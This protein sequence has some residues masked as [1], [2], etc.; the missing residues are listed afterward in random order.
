MNYRSR[1]LSFSFAVVVILLVVDFTTKGSEANTTLPSVERDFVVE[2]MFPLTVANGALS[3]GYVVA[4]QAMIYEIENINARKDV[5]PNATLA[6]E[7]FNDQNEDLHLI[8]AEAIRIVSQYRPSLECHAADKEKLCTKDNELPSSSSKPRVSAIIGPV[9]SGNTVPAASLLGLYNIPLIGFSASSSLLSDKSRFKSFL[10]TIPSDKY[11][12]MA[13]ASLVKRFGWNYVFFIASDDE[14]GRQGLASFK[15]AARELNVCT[16]SDVNIAFQGDEAA[17]QVREVVARLKKE[18]RVKVVVLFM[19]GSQAAAIVNEAKRQGVGNITWIFSDAIGSNILK[20]NVS[21][22]QLRGAFTIDFVYESIPQFEKYLAGITVEDARGNYWLSKLLESTLNCSISNQAGVGGGNAGGGNSA[23]RGKRTCLPREKLDLPTADV[24]NVRSRIVN[25]INGVRAIAYGLDD[26]L[27]CRESGRCPGKA[28]PVSGKDLYE[29]IQNATFV[30]AIGNKTVAFDE[31]GD[32]ATKEYIFRNLAREPAT[33]KLRFVNV[34]TWS[35]ESCKKLCF[36]ADVEWNT[37][38]KP[39]STCSPS[40]MPGEKQVGQSVCCWACERCPKRMISVVPGAT[41]CTRCPENYYANEG[42][43]R[44]L[45]VKEDRVD[46]TD[47]FSIIIVTLSCLS[48]VAMLAVSVLFVRVRD[49]PL[50]RDS[51]G[52]LLGLFVL[53]CALAFVFSIFQVTLYRTDAA[54]R[55]LNIFLLFVIFTLVTT[56]LA[57]TKTCDNHLRLIASHLPKPAAQHCRLVMFATFLLFQLVLIAIWCTIHAP[58][59]HTV[60]EN[61]ASQLRVCD[62][63]WSAAQFIAYAFPLLMLVMATAFA[64]KERDDRANHSEA[65]YISFCTISLCILLIAFF[66][67]YRF[68]RGVTTSIVIATTSLVGAF[69]VIGCVILPKVYILLVHPQRNVPGNQRSNEPTVS[70]AHTVSHM[71]SAS[72]PEFVRCSETGEALRAPNDMELASSSS[73]G[74]AGVA[75]DTPVL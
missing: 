15:I 34:A 32:R 27:K 47:P 21:E 58:A 11:Q 10:R 35:S 13:M 74:S 12:A 3:V 36:L 53:S 67:T 39:D 70:S 66:P 25:I 46:I 69:A 68:V 4:M 18:E 57:K 7:I 55:F 38:R 56:L 61:E 52:L 44:C 50:V 1:R 49:T 20:H 45:R 14:Y 2:G 24:A 51:G 37:G 9:T 5:L 23:V 26:L 8:M 48:L 16:A 65:K 64:F 30:G 43:T 29:S 6:Y 63:H 54:C 19:F 42:Q 72:Q 31:R 33:G 17:R 75:K 22:E 41:N 62:A 71:G 73:G 40:C 28:A 60:Q 59:A